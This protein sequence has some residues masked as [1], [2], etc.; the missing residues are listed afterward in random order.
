MFETANIIEQIKVTE[1]TFKLRLNVPSMA[2][3]CKPGQ[4]VMLKSWES[5][6]PFLLRPISLNGFD[7]ETIT[8][9]YKVKGRGTK[10]MSEAKVG[11]T[12]QVLGPLGQGFPVLDDAKCVAVIGRGIGIAPLRPLVEA[13]VKKGVKVYA[14]LSAKAESDLF[15]KEYFESIGV[16][17]RSTTAADKNVTDFFIEDCKSV[18]FSAAYSCGSKRLAADMQKMHKEYGF[19]AYISLEE[20]M[21]CGVGACKGCVVTAY[22][23]VD[24]H[25]YYARVCKDGPVFDVDRVMK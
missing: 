9:L 17:V 22:D 6:D 4:F 16:V 5:H 2:L 19:P 13:Y 1:D 15:D 14:Y 23:E 20:H 11:E 10:L 21:A 25:E 7:A 3:G 18:S 12:M 8:L 24:G